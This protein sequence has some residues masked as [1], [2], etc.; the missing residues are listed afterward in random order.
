MNYIKTLI[1]LFLLSSTCVIAQSPQDSLFAIW[2]NELQPKTERLNALNEYLYAFRTHPDTILLLSNEMYALAKRIESK[3]YQVDATI[4]SCRAYLYLGDLEKALE[5]GTQSSQLAKKIGYHFGEARALGLIAVYHNYKGDPL[6][7]IEYRIASYEVARKALEENPNSLIL[8]ELKSWPVQKNIIDNHNNI[9]G[10]IYRNMGAYPKALK[11]YELALKDYLILGNELMVAA[12]QNN[13]AL[14]HMKMEEYDKAMEYFRQ[15]LP[16]F[17]ALGN[18]EFEANAVGN[19][20]Y[21][22][23]IRK[24]YNKAEEYMDRHLK[25]RKEI[26][27]PLYIGRAY[28][29][30]GHLNLEMEDYIKAFQYLDMAENI[31]S[32][33][34]DQANTDMIFINMYRGDIYMKQGKL[35]KSLLLFEKCLES[36]NEMHL[37]SLKKDAIDYLYQINKKLGMIGKAL[38]FHEELLILNDSLNK[39]ETGKKLMQ[40]DFSNKFVADSLFQ[41]EEKKRV[42]LVFEK[43]ILQKTNTRNIFLGLGIMLLII[44]GGLWNRL[45]FTRKSRNIIEKERDRS[46]NLLLNILP[47]E[48]AEEL[49]EKGEA[50]ARDFDMVSI[51][52]TDFKDFTQTSEKL[53]AKELVD[54]LNLCFKRF[55]E[56]MEKYGIEK[57]KTIGDAYMAAGGLPVSSNEAT[58]N[59][60]LAALDMQEFI[61]KRKAEQDNLGLMGFEMRAGIHTGPI[62][63]GIVGV[64]KF[65]YDIWGDTVNT[66]SRMESFGEVGHVNISQYTYELIKDDTD[67]AFTKRKKIKVKGKG[68]MAMYF[69]E[70]TLDKNKK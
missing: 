42:Q 15:A 47:S 66:A 9:L 5:A 8:G 30:L 57:I 58:K 63:A 10:E 50:K 11:Y 51:I 3:R 44:S 69:I 28:S 1:L 16:V 36:A 60:V 26:G 23:E 18:K 24:S 12:V 19:I 45:K 55:D 68:E 22:Y 41:I 65:Q 40:V 25:A 70:R 52:F 17:E 43:E 53:T 49:K 67:F 62:I 20:G 27:N 64:K 13:F 6:R 38:K 4:Q 33:I 59:T 61:K 2:Q 21:I 39:D 7:E 29:S 31:F 14:V 37:L 56:I 46:D 35:K 32:T 34:N 54:E 48:V